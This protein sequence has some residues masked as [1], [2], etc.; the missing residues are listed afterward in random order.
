VVAGLVL[1][2]CGLAGIGGEDDGEDA[3]NTEATLSGDGA[4]DSSAGADDGDS[5]TATTE[6][7]DQTD[8]DGDA[9][10]AGTST[11]EP[12][13]TQPTEGDTA[14]STTDADL[15]PVVEAGFCGDGLDRVSEIRF[16]DGGSGSIIDV[17]AGANQVDLYRLDVG[18]GQIMTI[19]L[20]SDDDAAGYGLLEPGQPPLNG[21]FTELI[22]EDTNAG[23]NWICADSGPTG[24]GYRLTVTVIN[25]NSPTKIDAPWC[26]DSV[27][28]RG[29]IRFPAGEFSTTINQAV[30]LGERDLYTFTA[31][32]GQDLELFIL[33][34][35]AVFDLRAPSGEIIFG[36]VSDFR[37]PLPED[38]AY[39]VCVGSIR[40]N[41]DYDLFVS[42]D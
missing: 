3:A 6:T 8:S 40:G 38:G 5:I 16:N 42:I 23:T 24:A 20:T 11:D 4:G 22:V 35:N 27:N 15:I 1:G 30:I 32:A 37:I 19:A 39:S 21:P 41:A 28:D 10:K 17:N 12:T 29:E 25:N 26:G 9:A 36:D 31:S 7:G 2:A 33:D 34:E 18:D 14:A 13:T